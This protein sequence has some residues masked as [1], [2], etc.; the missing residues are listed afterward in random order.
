MS[1]NDWK[2]ATPVIRNTPH[3]Q[4]A[5]ERSGLLVRVDAVVSCFAALVYN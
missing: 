3:N 2:A 5:M 1:G 4:L